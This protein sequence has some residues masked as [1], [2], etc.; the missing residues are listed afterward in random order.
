MGPRIR[1]V[2]QHLSS[3]NRPNQTT[4]GHP[5]HNEC[6][7]IDT[8]D[9]NEANLL[10]SVLAANILSA[11][12]R[13]LAAAT[14]ESWH[15]DKVRERICKVGARFTFSGRRVVMAIAG[16]ARAIWRALWAEVEKI[17]LHPRPCPDG[18]LDQRRPANRQLGE[19]GPC[20]RR[21]ETVSDSAKRERNVAIR[22]PIGGLMNKMGCLESVQ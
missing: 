22:P 9:S 6:E 11:L 13:P 12:R 15:L 4:Q 8:T 10:L 16:T 3:A 7:L 5:I 21:A 1:A 19:R 20:I 17:R 14:G 18:C 2:P